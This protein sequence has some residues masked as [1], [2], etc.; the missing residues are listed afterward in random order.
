MA[1]LSGNKVLGPCIVAIMNYRS[2]CVRFLLAINGKGINMEFEQTPPPPPA[3]FNL[4]STALS[5][6]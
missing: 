2:I 3:T 5:R 4:L 1:K 6:H